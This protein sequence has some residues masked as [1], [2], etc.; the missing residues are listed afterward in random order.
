[1]QLRLISVCLWFV[2]LL[3]FPVLS[4]AQLIQAI[5]GSVKRSYKMAIAFDQFGNAM[6]GGSEDETISSRAGR[7]MEE[8]KRWGCVLCKFLDFFEKD[9]CMKSRGMQFDM[10]KCGT[11]NVC[12]KACKIE[13]IEKPAGVLCWLYKDG[14][15][16][17]YENRPSDCATYQCVYVT[18]GSISLKYRPD[19]LG[20]VFEQPFGKS[21]WVGVELEENALQKEDCARLVRAMN[22]AGASILLKS[23]DG[24][25]QHSLPPSITVEE[26]FREIH[27]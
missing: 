20:V 15:C 1:M 5:F 10:N 26:F 9:H 24:K 25:F 3:F 27:S 16:S 8:G 6:L 23:L 2:C 4:V 17:D 21:Y 7:A 19:N 14:G 13:A 11:C 22:N 18:Q 12:C